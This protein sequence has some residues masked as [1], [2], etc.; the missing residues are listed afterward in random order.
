[1]IGVVTQSTCLNS[2]TVIVV[3][4]LSSFPLSRTRFSV[5][6][7]EMAVKSILVK[8]GLK[9]VSHTF[10][11]NRSC[12]RDSDRDQICMTSRITR[13]VSNLT[14][15]GS[16][17]GRKVGPP[18]LKSGSQ[19]VN[20]GDEDQMVRFVFRNQMAQVIDEISP[21]RKSPDTDGVYSGLS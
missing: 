11:Y 14:A 7:P 5:R 19:Y 17:Q 2:L 21:S 3:P 4:R 1:M 9:N 15:N 12:D 13:P 20:P 18:P 10:V 16:P 8:F 6:V